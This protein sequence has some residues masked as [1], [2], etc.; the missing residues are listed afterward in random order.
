MVIGIFSWRRARQ[1]S[2]LRRV[3]LLVVGLLCLLL[4]SAAQAQ[5]ECP[6][7][8]SWYRVECG[9]LAVPEDYA[10]ADSPLIEMAYVRVHSASANPLPEPVLFINGGPGGAT[11]A[12]LPRILE[13]Y[14]A[15]L[16]ER[17]MIFFDPRGVG[18][19]TPALDCTPEAAALYPRTVDIMFGGDLVPVARACRARLAAQGVDVAQYTTAALAQDIDRLRAALGYDDWHVYSSSY[20]TQVALFLLRDFPQGV[21]SVVLDSTIPPG[22]YD[23]APRL[24]GVFALCAADF[25]CRAAYPQLQAQYAELIA[26]LEAA[27][28]TLSGVTLSGQQLDGLLNN[29]LAPN[30]YAAATLPALIGD[31]SEGDGSRLDELFENVSAPLEAGS[32]ALSGAAFTTLC[33]ETVPYMSGSN[34]LLT[35]EICAAWDAGRPFARVTQPVQSAVPTLLIAGTYDVLTP[36][37]NAEYAAQGLSRGQIVQ[38]PAGHATTIMG[39]PCLTQMAASFYNNPDALD[40]GC[41]GRMRAP[42]FTVRAQAVT[43]LVAGAVALL[44]VFSLAAGARIVPA[45]L[46]GRWPLA[47]RMAWRGVGWLPLALTAIVMLGAYVLLAGQALSAEGAGLPGYT[48]RVIEALLPLAVGVLAALLF[49]PEDEPAFEIQAASPRPLYYLVL[50]RAGLLLALLG[51]LALAGLLLARFA[52]NGDD[53]LLGTLRWL[54]PSLFLA[55]LALAISVETRRSAF[56]LL[57]VLLLWIGMSVGYHALLESYPFAYPFYLFYDPAQNN[58]ALVTLNRLF[59]TLAGMALLLWA[60]LRTG[61]EERLLKKG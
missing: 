14:A 48:V 53:L 5:P 46:A 42:A 60:C 21:R 22:V 13:N 39:A 9:R 40:T 32:S 41:V 51:A 44:G 52:L 59:L 19:S 3:T 10:R 57:A 54:P 20:G 55:G 49:A 8:I 29:V 18:F 35:P 11:L 1:V 56:A 25:V 26:R 24:Q 33:R 2:S 16:A 50:E 47:W 36:L 28:M 4:V 12:L 61:N 38:V 6:A 43:P 31:L 58:P 7:Q 45:L 17:D 34:G 30:M 15:I 23:Q 27:P 37:A